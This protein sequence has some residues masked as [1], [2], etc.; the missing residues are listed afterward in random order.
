MRV[1]QEVKRS[2]LPQ[3]VKPIDSTWA[4]KKKSNGTRRGRLTA[5]GFKQID[6]VDYDSASIH[7]PVTNTVSVRLMLTNVDGWLDSGSSRRQG[8]IFAWAIYRW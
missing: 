3:G 2:E 7:A 1:F 8:S 5:R 6:G 4:L